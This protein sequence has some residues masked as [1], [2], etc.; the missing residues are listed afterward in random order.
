MSKLKD[1]VNR[2]D[3]SQANAVTVLKENLLPS[4]ST[5][6]I[7]QLSQPDKAEK[8]TEQAVKLI[9]QDDFLDELETS[10]GLPRESET[11]DEFVSRAKSRMKALLTK[12]LK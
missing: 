1:I 12:K 7:I 4:I 9:T 10:I 5:L 3:P 2:N 6:N 11:E 8:F